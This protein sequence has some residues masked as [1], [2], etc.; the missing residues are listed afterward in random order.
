MYR[1]VSIT[2][3]SLAAILLATLSLADASADDWTLSGVMLA[4]SGTIIPDGA[5]AVSGQKI[6]SAGESSTVPSSATAIKV[7]GIIL[8]GFIDLH[9]HLT[10]NILP[11]WLP[12]RTFANR[13]EWQDSAEYDRFLTTPHNL[14]LNAAACESE[15]YAEVKAL[16]G[17]ATSVVGSLLPGSHPENAKCVKGLARNL[18][19][20]SGLPFTPPA[21]DDPCN[22]G[23]G[24]AIPLDVVDYEVFPLEM[25]HARLDY[26]LCELGTGNLRSLIVPLSEGSAGDSGA[27]R[28]FTM[29]SK[30][31]TMPPGLIFV[32][33]TAL[34]PEDFA[35]MTGVGLV[36][37]PR[38]NDELY[39]STTNIA[40][41]QQAKIAVSIAPD[42][43]PS[44]SAG[45][46]QE[47]A[48]AARHHFIAAD[49]LIDMAT[50][51]PA[52]M[53][54]LDAQIGTLAAGKFADIIVVDAKIDTTS[55]RPLDPVVKASPADIELVVVGGQAL[56]GDPALL[57]KFL[58]QGTKLDTLTVCGVQ[59]AVYLGQSGA[60]DLG[61]NLSDIQATLNDALAKAGSKIPDIECY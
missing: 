16:A 18:D 27:H 1:F 8:P 59:K 5:I 30:S 12:G 51:S 53:A 45:V 37:S 23:A 35:K 3:R 25:P 6:T 57:A 10:W 55:K 28:E 47:I 17:G 46:L 4:P 61:K 34:R 50:G 24:S 58:P 15:I 43:S 26:L 54:R 48:Y 41:A 7:P 44:G 56:Y 31:S 32:H 60:A 19:V 21:A 2:A 9:N 52:K 11:R 33:G 14:A 22:K 13:Y 42:W 40:A 29:F 36:W 39:G 49:Q 20:A 38:S